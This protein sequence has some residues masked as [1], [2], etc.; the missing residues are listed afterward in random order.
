MRLEKIKLAGF[1]SFVD[2]TTVPL[3]VNL[4]GVVG[5]N[6]CGKSNI[7]DAVRWVM[8][9]SS[10]KNL[11]GGSMAD[12]IFNGSA[13]RK[14]ISKASVELVFDNSDGAAGG[15]YAKYS[16]LSI[17]REVTRDGQSAY[18]LNGVRCRRRDITDIF[19]GTGLGPRSYAI[20][21][22][23]MI[24]RLIEAKP[25][26]LRVFLEEAAGVSKYKERRHETEIRMR[27]TRENLERLNDL[28]EEL[29]QQLE[30]LKR[31][32][33]AAERYK[34]FRAEERRYRLELLALRWQGF[35]SQFEQQNLKTLNLQTA[36]EQ[37]TA[38]L[39]K[40]DRIVEEA[41]IEHQDQQK[42][43][44]QIQGKFY[45]LG[46]E[47]AR[48]EQAIRHENSLREQAE[49]Q[50]KT[51]SDES[52]RYQNNLEQENRQLAEFETEESS[53]TE[54][55]NEALAAEEKAVSAQTGATR[56]VQEWQTDWD[57]LQASLAVPREEVKTQQARLRFFSEQLVQLE[58]RASRVNAEKGQLDSSDKDDSIKELETAVTELDKE[59][60]VQNEQ[61]LEID[62]G[63]EK[64]RERYQSLSAE[65]DHARSSLREVQGKRASLEK[66]LEH[67]TG[68][69]RKE[70]NRW[71][72][73]NKL[74]GSPRLLEK[75][76]VANGWERAAETILSEFVEAVCVEN[77]DELVGC[78]AQL[79]NE[80]VALLENGDAGSA[81]TGSSNR[82]IEKIKSP[83]PVGQFFAKVHCAQDLDE[84]RAIRKEL[85]DGESVITPDGIWMG[86]GWILKKGGEN[87]EAGILQKEKELKSLRKEEAGLLKQVQQ[88]ENDR[89]KENDLLKKQ[90]KSRTELRQQAS[91]IQGELSQ[92]KSRLAAMQARM[93]QS[94]KR[95]EII[96][97][98][99]R[100]IAEE[101]GAAIGG[102]EEAERLLKEAENQAR[103]FENER[104]Q[105]IE[106][107]DLLRAALEEANQSARKARDQVHH[108]KS[109]QDSILANKGFAVK[110]I[111]RIKQ[112]LEQVEARI[113]QISQPDE[114]SRAEAE[115]REK[116]HQ[117]LLEQRHQI[118]AD[119]KRGREK[120][121]LI[122][123]SIREKSSERQRVENELNSRREQ[124]EKA[125]IAQEGVVVHRETVMEQLQEKNADISQLIEAM[126][127]DANE[128]SWQENIDRLVSKIDRLGT[129]NLAAIEEHETV[130]E[131]MKYLEDQHKD[132]SE[133]LESL[134]QAI[135]KIDRETRALFKETFNKVNDG[136][137]SRFPKLFGGGRAFLQLDDQ[138]L[139]T[140]GVSVMAS[141]PG[142]RNSSI[143]LLSGG[144]KA[145]TA[146]A[147]VFSIF[148]LNPAPFCLLDEVDAPL[149]DANVGRYSELVKEMSSQVQ[150]LFISHNKTT[151]EIAQHLA[152][153][154]MSEPGISRMVSVD[155]DEAV[156]LAAV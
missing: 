23:G 87:A 6:G 134:E 46:A 8:G 68:R 154:T 146:V 133:S 63:I 19:L 104:E 39:Q 50:L 52:V 95:L 58:K 127:D 73:S 138:D 89:Q 101:N 113:A 80:G 119:L 41:R 143:H 22:Q 56:S 81:G 82:L 140:T 108:L 62:T 47:I 77:S 20:I 27:H 123:L 126:P 75:I 17:K 142:K 43:V 70:L 120:L 48:I 115:R 21:E 90:E 45:E 83:T 150:F 147:L 3:L 34:E 30:K 121:N 18:H 32:A 42:S 110:N 66:M 33:R 124:L 137:Q 94:R 132:L 106:Q 67:S 26:D 64:S 98:E 102:K 125:R 145:L 103:G 49:N 139:L 156:K 152:G 13:T 4:V 96:E 97:T 91:R 28:R 25:E 5:P 135:G 61:L 10:A 78:L 29:G 11:R 128:Q 144:E 72:E 105:N 114:A 51:A 7:I 2:P 112:H 53:L 85:V 36:L 117:E 59:Y 129:I 122:D 136:F 100:E 92:R 116:E 111:E 69:N 84:A 71:L 153:V 38:E 9:E 79:G 1:K 40:L 141:P 76:E 151:M 99:L 31:Q 57:K 131:R 15:E 109:R 65:S 24:S 118:E 35:N 37:S 155:I 16:Q 55:L 54:R 74:A 148:D 149:D 12:V 60:V 130:S 86:A 88:L 93:E 107:R 44:D 14:P